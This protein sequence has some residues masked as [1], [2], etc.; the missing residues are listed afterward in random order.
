ML[1]SPLRAYRGSACEDCDPSLASSSLS[2]VIRRA[3][4]AASGFWPGSGPAASLFPGLIPFRSS[5]SH[6]GG[7]GKRSVIS[8]TLRVALQ[9]AEQRVG[10]AVWSSEGEPDEVEVG[11][12]HGAHRGAIVGVVARLEHVG[13]VQRERDVPA[14]GSLTNGV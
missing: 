9:P 1:M 8:R 2:R 14:L 4:A 12:G 11:G 3:T 13:G 6:A 7:E 10:L 5:I